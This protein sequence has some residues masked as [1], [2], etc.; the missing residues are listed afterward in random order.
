MSADD[1][2]MGSQQE[3]WGYVQGVY[4][5]YGALVRQG[6][7]ADPQLT[8]AVNGITD[9]AAKVSVN[10]LEQTFTTWL[11]LNPDRWNEKMPALFLAALGTYGVLAY[12]VSQRSHEI[13]IRMAVGAQPKEVVRMIARQGVTLGIVG[14]VIGG[15]LTLPLIGLLNSLLQGLST[16]KPLT[17]VSIGSLLFAVT[18]V[19]SLVPANRAA[20]IDPV[21]TLR[22]E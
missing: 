13:G 6:H 14:L 2:M 1:Y 21:R 9:C 4:D 8:A 10:E 18:V 19:A 7:A 20:A 11:E 22:D 16:V 12:S 5:T 15:L 3:R 17:L